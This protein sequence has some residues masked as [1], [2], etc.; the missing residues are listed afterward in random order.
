MN[1]KPLIFLMIAY[2]LFLV[3][4]FNAT[5]IILSIPLNDCCRLRKIDIN[6]YDNLSGDVNAYIDSFSEDQDIMVNVEFKGWAFIQT[7]QDNGNN[8]IKLIFTSKDNHYEVDT[9]LQERFDLK[10]VF[11]ENTIYGYKHGFITKFSPLKMENGIYKLYIYCYENDEAI[12]LMDTGKLYKK[13]YRG[14]TEN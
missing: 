13:T 5:D 6:K 9:E 12:G 4:F 14:F 10:I 2:L 8:N 11:T 1:K 3:V 7:E